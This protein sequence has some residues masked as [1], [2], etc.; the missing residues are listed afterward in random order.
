MRKSKGRYIVSLLSL[1]VFVIACKTAAVPQEAPSLEGVW[2]GE[3]SV[4]TFTVG[5]R[6]IEVPA[7]NVFDIA[8][9]SDGAVQGALTVH[10]FL[11]KAEGIPPGVPDGMQTFGVR[12]TYA[13][14][15]VM[16]TMYNDDGT[17][18]SEQS[19]TISDDGRALR[20]TSTAADGD[21]IFVYVKQ[22][23]G[24]RA[25]DDSSFDDSSFDDS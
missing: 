5:G 20:L 18:N 10:V 25:D 1:T 11:S 2:E 4:S 12:G 19:G 16:L 13:Y 6:A 8:G 24:G 7:Q 14:P 9:V 23:D 3:E 17:I 15:Q 21:T 22:T